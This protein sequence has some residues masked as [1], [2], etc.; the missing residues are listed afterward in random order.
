MKFVCVKCEDFITFENVQ[1]VAADKRG[2]A[3]RIK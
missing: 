3:R 1:E 2:I